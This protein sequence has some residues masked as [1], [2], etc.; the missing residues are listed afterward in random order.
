[1]SDVINKITGELLKSVHTPDYE[2]DTDWIVNPTQE[3]IDSI[4]EKIVIKEM[5]TIDYAEKINELDSVSTLSATKEKL[6]S[7]FRLVFGI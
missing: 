7:L 3:Q 4:K 6:K 2:S 5:P 1:M